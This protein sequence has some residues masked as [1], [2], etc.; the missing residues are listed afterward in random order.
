MRDIWFICDLCDFQDLCELYDFC[1][2]IMMVWLILLLNKIRFENKIIIDMW[3][4]FINLESVVVKRKIE[5][6]EEVL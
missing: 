6:I 4:C 3:D 5:R 1:E 2:V